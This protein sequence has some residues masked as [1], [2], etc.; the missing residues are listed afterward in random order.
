MRKTLIFIGLFLSF[1]FA[2]HALAQGFVSL[3]PIPGLT[4]TSATSVINSATLASFFNNLYKYLIGLAATLA[5]IQIIWAGIEIA[6]NK[7]N[8][9]KLLDE[10]GKIYNAIFGLVLVLSPA[11]IFS[12]INPSILNL[13]LDLPPIK[14]MASSSTN[15][16]GGATQATTDTVSGCMVSGTSGILQ[17]AKCPTADSGQKQTDLCAQS[18][19]EISIISQNTLTDG[20]IASS[21]LMCA[22][23]NQY[24][25]IDT[26]N[27]GTIGWFVSAFN[28]INNVQPL[29]VASD[30]QNNAASAI[31][32]ASTCSQ[33]GL[34]TCISDPTFS[35][36][37]ECTPTPKTP[38]PGLARKCGALSLTC[39][40]Y[41]S[42]RTLASS[43][44]STNPSWTPFQ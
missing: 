20:T 9:S 2:S 10:K 11:L 44:C 39:R 33:S 26:S 35:S 30:N 18:G 22:W 17:I 31:Q 1:G 25:F 13:S 40:D 37:S 42:V 28:A 32:F 12:I 36:P 21:V 4:D 14:P 23:S 6:M 29:A 16:A 24:V 27:Q 19:G 7:D 34:S 3:A 8:A 43:L 38:L 15:V 5:V 41:N